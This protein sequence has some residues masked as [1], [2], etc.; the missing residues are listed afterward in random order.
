MIQKQVRYNVE[1]NPQES[2]FFA[3]KW[4]FM[5]IDL[6]SGI[7]TIEREI[8]SQF[9]R[10]IEPKIL[11]V[12]SAEPSKYLYS[13]FFSFSTSNGKIEQPQKIHS[14]LIFDKNLTGKDDVSLERFLR[15][16]IKG[17]R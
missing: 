8:Y 16:I 9:D 1:V 6:E 7:K 13:K 5:I 11:Y 14:T 4:T 15:E 2:E 3:N 12:Q 10:I 17:K